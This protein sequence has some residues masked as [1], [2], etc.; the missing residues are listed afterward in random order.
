MEAVHK[1]GWTPDSLIKALKTAGFKDARQTP[2]QYKRKEPRDFR[3]EAI[4]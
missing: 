3:V 1:S 4:K 2:A